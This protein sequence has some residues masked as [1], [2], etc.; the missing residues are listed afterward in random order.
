MTQT[1]KHFIDLNDLVA[2]R[3]QCNECGASLALPIRNQS[4]S[5]PQNCPSYKADWYQKNGSQINMSDVIAT[6]VSE[7]KRVK[8][9]LSEHPKEPLGFTLDVEVSGLPS[10]PASSDRI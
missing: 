1:V 6:F 3:V 2:L 9:L 5:V 7:L 4:F 8:R 10:I